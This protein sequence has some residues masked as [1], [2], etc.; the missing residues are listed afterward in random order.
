MRAI[1]LSCGMGAGILAVR[2]KS[3]FPMLAWDDDHFARRVAGSNFP[4]VPFERP[5]GL[6][7]E[8]IPH[9]DLLVC[10][11]WPPDAWSV[12]AVFS[13][14]VIVAEGLVGPPTGYRAWVDELEPRRFGAPLVGKRRMNVMLREDL[15]PVFGRFPFPDGRPC[16]LQDVLRADL[17]RDDRKGYLVSVDKPCR[18]PRYHKGPFP[19]VPGKDGPRRLTKP[20]SLMLYG[21]PPDYETCG[22]ASLH[23]LLSQSMIPTMVMAI[24]DE[25][26]TWIDLT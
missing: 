14:R 22:N 17:P 20:E 8:R 4:D 18:K 10:K 7:P 9:A 21:F 13:P 19:M 3:G 23:R 26:R 24:I 6:S 16:V 25:L 5:S 11:G 12:L 15:R 2:K 1:I